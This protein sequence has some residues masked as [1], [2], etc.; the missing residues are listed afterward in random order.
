M[1]RFLNDNLNLL[2]LKT[3]TYIKKQSN[4]YINYLHNTEIKK[5]NQNINNYNNKKIF[6]F[7]PHNYHLPNTIKKQSIDKYLINN[8]ID[9]KQFNII[10]QYAKKILNYKN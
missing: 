8:K 9:K 6:I 10:Q 4:S 2:T 5:Y 1:F 3:C 7:Y